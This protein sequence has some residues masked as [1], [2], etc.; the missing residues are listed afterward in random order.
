MLLAKKDSDEQVFLAEDQAWMESSSD[1]DQEINANMVFMAQ[2]EKVLSESDKSS[3]TAEETIAETVHM[4]IPSK[5]ILY[6]GRKEICFENPRYFEKAKDLRPSLYD[7]KVIGLGYTPMF[8]TH[9]DEALEIEKFKRSKENKIEFAYDYG[10]LNASYLNGLEAPPTTINYGCVPNGDCQVA[11]NAT[12]YKY[13]PKSL[14]DVESSADNKLYKQPKFYEKEH[15]RFNQQPTTNNQQGHR[16][17]SAFDRLSKT[18][19]PSTT[20]SRPQ[21]TDSRDSSRGRN[22]TRTLS[23][24]KDDRHKDREC[25]RGTRESFKR[26]YMKGS[27]KVEKNA[28]DS[29]NRKFDADH[30]NVANNVSGKSFA[31]VVQA[32]RI[33]PSNET[34]PVLILEDDFL[35]TKDFTLSLMGRVKEMAS[36]ANLKKAHCNEGFDVVKISNLGKVYW[37]RASKVPGWSSE[38]SKEEEEDDT[39]VEDNL[40]GRNNDNEANNGF[41]ESDAEEVPETLF[42]QPDDQ[43]NLHSEDPFGIYPLLNKDNVKVAQKVIFEDHSLSHPPGFTPEGDLNDGNNANLYSK[44]FGENKRG[45]YSSVN[46][47]D[48]KDN[49]DLVNKKSESKRSGCPKYPVLTRTGG[50]ILN[51]MEEVVKVGQTM[52]YNMDGCI[53]D[54]TEI[55]ESQGESGEA[56]ECMRISGFMHGVNNPELTKRLNEHVPKTMEEM[57]ITTT[58]F[59]RGEAA[60]ASK[61]KGHVSWKPHDQSKRH[62]ADKRT[63]KEI[64]ATEASNFQP[65]PPMVTPIEELVRAGKLLHLIKEIKQGR[66]QSKAGKKETVVKDK[67][68]TIYMVQSWQRTVKQKVTQTL[69]GWERSLPSTVHGMLKF[70]VEGGI[71]T[72]RSTILI[73]AE[74]AS[75]TT[76]PV[77]PREEKSRPANFTIALHP[78]FSDQEVV[79]GGSLSDKGRTALCSVLKKNLDIFSWQPSDMT[80]APERAKAIQAEVQKLVDAEIMREVYYHNWLSNPVMVKKHDAAGGCVSISRT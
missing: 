75:V 23:A 17:Q 32:N 68:T 30:K 5:D 13:Q 60:A 37:V 65:P 51:L 71:A 6:N 16:R 56:P 21:R 2:I 80:G 33:K 20:K 25:L 40:N 46:P 41:E 19:S 50:S 36:L 53:T 58:A 15:E 44:N 62:S 39:S 18:Y 28:T 29:N 24:P 31:S 76:S 73:P 59:I 22:R 70:S 11:A 3:S 74:C 72:I 78:D 52:G 9:S 14:S 12:E 67:P 54:I 4:I 49:S 7:E 79:I 55:I 77:I 57:I 8:L 69:S 27:G 34:P 43:K 63:P 26:D 35:N 64:L 47:D 1:F 38:F 66:D 10:N 48:D 42:E 45:D 61:K